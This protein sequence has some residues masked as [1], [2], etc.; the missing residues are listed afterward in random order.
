M[1]TALPFP[2]GPVAL[3]A[4]SRLSPT[5]QKVLCSLLCART[6]KEIACEL[7]VSVQTVSKHH[8]HIWR[9][10]KVKNDVELVLKV[11]GLTEPSELQAVSS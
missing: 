11:A 9:K 3:T 5:E 4:I 7:R 10:L 1:G 2:F 8:Q 6:N